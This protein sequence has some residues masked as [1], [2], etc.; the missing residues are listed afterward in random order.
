M[1]K[2]KWFL[3]RSKENGNVYQ[4][5]ISKVLGTHTAEP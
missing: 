5:G 3:G 1:S 4:T 2:A